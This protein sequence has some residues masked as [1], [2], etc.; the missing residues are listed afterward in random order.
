MKTY[1]NHLLVAGVLTLGLSACSPKDQSPQN[2]GTNKPEQSGEQKNILL[3]ISDDHGIDQLGCYGNTVIQTPNLDRLAEQGIRMN[4][5]YAVAASCSASRGAILSGMFPHQSGQYG[6]NHNWHHFSYF[7]WVESMPQLLKQQGYQTACIGKLHVGPDTLLPFDYRVYEEEIMMNRDVKTM[8]DK[9]GELFNQD[10][11]KPFFLLMGYSDPHR[12]PHGWSDMPGIENWDG[13]G[14]HQ[15]YPGV[16]PVVYK[17]ED[18]PVPGFLNDTEAVRE[19]LAEMYQSI[20]RMDKGIGMVLDQLEKSGRLENTLIIYIS[21]NGIPFPGAKTTIYDS[22]VRMPMIVSYPGI[23]NKGGETNAMIS[24]TDILPTFLDWAGADKP[25]YEL[26]GRSFLTAMTEKDPAGWNEVMMSHTFHEITMY[27]PMRALRNKKYKY[28]VN[29][30][31]ELEYPFATDLFICKT[32]QDILKNNR[33][34]MGKRKVKDY[35]KRPAE[36][37]YDIVN[38]P[39][40]SV[41]LANDPAYAEVLQEM[42]D[43]LHKRQTDTKDPWLILGNYDKNTEFLNSLN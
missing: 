14:N 34:T 9:A 29:L 43:Q 42:R 21:D 8:A 36:E 15:D 16:E 4:N 27:Y 17:P 39:A 20:S 12:M 5:A 13:F 26:P 32:W 22:G 6:H 30:F 38:D 24:F 1:T 3:L 31:P 37:L 2:Q 35:L 10:K 41:N 11:D 33:S 18:M 23:S 19:E 28:I 25:E 40:E 7:D